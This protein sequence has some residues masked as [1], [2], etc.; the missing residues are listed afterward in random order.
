MTEVAEAPG[1]E[2]AQGLKRIK[3]WINGTL[4]A[5]DSGRSGPV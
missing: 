2:R 3:H 5:G 4:V 1:A